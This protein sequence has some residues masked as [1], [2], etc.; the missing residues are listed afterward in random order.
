M[1]FIKLDRVDRLLVEVQHC[2]QAR[3]TQPSRQNPSDAQAECV[4]DSQKKIHTIALMRINHCGEVCAQALYR[5]QALLADAQENYE[6]L[7][8]AAAEEYDHLAWCRGRIYE[9]DGRT[10]VLVP[11]FYLQSLLLGVVIATRG[12]AVSFGFIAETERQVESHLTRHI[13]QLDVNDV[14]THAI[15]TQMKQDEVQHGKDALMRGGTLLPEWMRYGMS[16]LAK[17]MTKATYYC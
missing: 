3:H 8:N 13:A 17:V 1:T 14:K 9:L 7:L 2:L 5:G 15:L 6:Y 16:L 4:L 11:F 10:S 12:D